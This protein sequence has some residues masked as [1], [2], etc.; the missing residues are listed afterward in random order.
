M[1]QKEIQEVAKDFEGLAEVDT[2]FMAHE[3]HRMNPEDRLAVVQQIREDESKNPSP[4][5]PKLEFTD[6]G[7]FKSSDEKL[8]NGDGLH[9]EYDPAT[10]EL[11]SAHYAYTGASSRLEHVKCEAR[12]ERGEGGNCSKDVTFAN[13]GRIEYNQSGQINK[14]IYNP[15]WEKTIE[16]DASGR[17]S[18]LVDSPGQRSEW[19]L[20]RQPDGSWL[21]VSEGKSDKYP[22]YDIRVTPDGDLVFETQPGQKDPTTLLG[23]SKSPI[24]R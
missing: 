20:S 6:S 13:G 11:I 24:R 14:L 23:P 10:G 17:V 12:D 2:G 18:K 15:G 3:L 4:G 8:P 1:N 7:D 5:L 21:S 19:V 22:V 16:Y 9:A